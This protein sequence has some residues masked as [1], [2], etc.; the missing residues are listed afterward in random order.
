MVRKLSGTITTTRPYIPSVLD[1][2]EEPKGELHRIEHIDHPFSLIPV[3][4]NSP[5]RPSTSM[6]FL[7]HLYP[8][9]LGLSICSFNFALRG[10]APLAK[11]VHSYV[12]A[13]NDQSTFLE[14]SLPWG[15]TYYSK[16][17]FISHL[18][19]RNVTTYLTKYTHLY[20]NHLLYM[21]SLYMPTFLAI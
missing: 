6:T 5:L 9:F 2:L 15:Y 13:V 21:M 14:S 18:I 3:S 1:R 12:Y 20:S 11:L 16:N 4:N 10:W 19:S 8:C 7:Y 17:I